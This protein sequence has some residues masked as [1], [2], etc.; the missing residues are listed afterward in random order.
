MKYYDLDL[1]LYDYTT[2]DS[3]EG[4]SV[5]V[6]RTPAAGEQ[7]HDHADKVVVPDKLRS[8]LR[9]LEKRKLDVQ[10]MIAVG[11]ELAALLFPPGARSFLVRSHDKLEAGEALRV[12]LRIDRALAN[13][14]WEYVYIPPPD[15]DP[16]SKDYSG[17]LALDTTYS[18]VRYEELEQATQ[19]LKPVS[20]DELRLLA[21]LASPSDPDYPPLKVGEEANIDN[22]VKK[23]PRISAN[24]CLDASR[25]KLADALIDEAHIFHFSGHG[26]FVSEMGEERNTVT[27]TGYIAL[28]DDSDGQKRADL[29]SAEELALRLAGRGVRLAVLSACQAGS[30]DGVNPWTG[31]AP[32]LV[33]RGIPAVLGMQYSIYDK[34]AIEFN[35]TFYQALA[36]GQPIDLAITLGRQVVRDIDPDG[37]DWGVPVLYLR[38]GPDDS[39]A[40]FPQMAATQWGRLVE[41]SR[42]QTET[43]LRALIGTPEKPKIYIPETYLERNTI[44]SNLA[45]FLTQE[46]RALIITG[47]SGTGKTCLLCRWTQRL[48]DKGHTV[49]FY[50]C[51]GPVESDI[52]R[53]VA[54]DLAVPPDDLFSTLDDISA[55]AVAEER[56]FIIIFD[57]I[58]EFGTRGEGPADLLSNINTLVGRLP[59]NVRVVMSCSTPTWNQLK[60][61]DKANLFWQFYYHPDGNEEPLL[62]EPF[63]PEEVEA[64][65]ERYRQIF[66][67]RT[68]FDNLSPGLKMQL[69]KPLLLR[70]LAMTHRGRAE[71]IAYEAEAMGI[72]RSYFHQEV[73]ADSREE[74][75]VGYVAAE[76]LSKQRSSVPK[77]SLRQQSEQVRALIDGNSANSENDEQSPYDRLLDRGVLVE[78]PGDAF[79]E[80]NLVGFTCTQIAAYALALYMGRLGSVDVERI[81]QLVQDSDRFA[82]AWYVART[83][84]MLKKDPAIFAALSQSSD[85]H[86]REIVVE[87]LVQLHADE[88]TTSITLTKQLLDSD[89]EQIQRTALKAALRIGPGARD[90]FVSA[91]SKGSAGL[92]QAAKDTL[93]LTGSGNLDFTYEVLNELAAGI[94]I[95]SLAGDLLKRVR[96]PSSA[97]DPTLEFIIDLS[98]A[99][100]INHCGQEDVTLKTDALYYDLFTNKLHLGLLNNRVVGWGLTPLLKAVAAVLAKQVVESMLMRQDEAFF[101]I[102]PAE[103]AALKQ[104][105]QLLEPDTNLAAAK[106]MLKKLLQ[107]DLILFNLAAAHLLPVHVYRDFATTRPLV[108]DLFDS[109]NARGRL[110]VLLSFAVLLPDTPPEWTPLLEELT[111]RLEEENPEAFYGD[112]LGFQEQFDI[113]M[114]PLGLAYGKVAREA[115]MPYFVELLQTK[116]GSGEVK[117]VERCLSGLGAIGFYYPHA[118]FQTL[119]AAINDFTGPDMQ[120]AL[121]H[122]LAVIRTLHFDEV[123]SFLSQIG[124]GENY[125]R[126]VS[127]AA[128]VELVRR[129]ISLLGHYNNVIHEV[130]HY[131]KMRRQLSI[132]MLNLLADARNLDTVVSEFT[133]VMIQMLKDAN[134]RLIE[135][136]R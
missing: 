34:S 72:Y 63:S 22:A 66:D 7:S 35:S 119:K 13:I 37:R 10:E 43:F 5:R 32:A 30:R 113:T 86:L 122:P 109:M 107:S 65:Y 82:L 21:A 31:V 116:L 126:R 85:L 50:D 106:P 89:S 120:E 136:T 62:L 121:L 57:G 54:R 132:G 108:L 15:A 125:Q 129:Y 12:R 64:A 79:E 96:K 41:R 105:A 115:P 134:F 68:P 104:L 77:R 4:F 24:Y 127:E 99:I 29:Y 58:N 112:L 2:A 55:S 61:D 73:P 8:K 67:L 111:R 124:V 3:V 46:K 18:L 16:E 75:L 94:G 97:S 59:A 128:D 71:P 69:R 135:W 36:Q 76:I 48:R 101:Q 27:G 80:G 110:W 90:I 14:P 95:R 40:L 26:I 123:D 74:D 17:F 42:Q 20:S 11:E 23:V 1:E 88:P 93:Y 53:M 92:R 9:S 49:F 44:E 6:L 81:A 91:A 84:L 28:I 51:N 56:R 83:F 39:S 118:V 47:G 98:V 33:W 52:E 117:K 131:P 103:R 100:Y 133:S 114:L 60:Q 70:L 25:R 87:S 130:I 19:S 45:D 38:T 78:I 102:P